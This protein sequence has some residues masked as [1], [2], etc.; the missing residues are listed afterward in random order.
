MIT[1][2][3]NL[4]RVLRHEVP[5]WIPVCG[6]VD[7]YNQPH[8][9]GMDPALAEELVNVQWHDMSTIAFSRYLGIDVAD[10]YYPPLAYRQTKVETEYRRDG[11]IHTTI[12]HCPSGELRQVQRFSP[13][14]GMYYTI[15]HQVK[16]PGDLP[17]L[18]EIFADTEF[19]LD[20]EKVEA[21]RVRR[22][23]VGDEGIV[24]FS[25]TGTPLGQLIRVHAGV[26]NTSILWADAEDEMR[27]LFAVMEEN[28]LRQFRLAAQADGVDIVL[29][30][31]DTSTTTQS[32]A[33][34]EACCLDYT[35]HVADALHAGGKYYFH[36]SC[37]LIRDLLHLYRQTKM[38]GVHGY[39]IKPMGDVSVADG[40]RLLGDR[41]VI[42]AGMIQLFLSMTDRDEVARSIRAMFEEGAPDNLMLGLAADP[43]K[44]MEE[45][46]FVANECK[47]YQQLFS[48]RC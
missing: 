36:H 25:M 3:E 22:E 46:A 23:V 21:L 9:A 28:H 20:P 12:W 39:T 30:M 34:F 16:E 37:G 6:H 32:P 1:P 19:C 41:I 35:D 48:R 7:P 2:R 4:L 27:A 14:T 10:F 5:E 15:E 31:D 8:K 11:D 26:E 38:D 42:L 47:K 40:K 29:G 18:A 17:L 33:M 24:M 45:T 43:E 13:D 44:T